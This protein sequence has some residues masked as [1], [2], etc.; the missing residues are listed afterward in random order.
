MDRDDFL[1][2]AALLIRKGRVSA[3]DVEK[4]TATVFFE[5]RNNMV[6]G[7]LKVLQN[8]PYIHVNVRAD[9]DYE[10]TA[11]YATTDRKLGYSGES[12]DAALPE[13]IT[14]DKTYAYRLACGNCTTSQTV[15]KVHKLELEIHPWLPKVGQEVLCLYLPAKDGDGFILG[16]L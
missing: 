16:G 9:E 13:R 7:E 3:V 8:H 6:S 11:S 14:L 15:E 4:R 5:D 1:K 10:R 12:F 2:T